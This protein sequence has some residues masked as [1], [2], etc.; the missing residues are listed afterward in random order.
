[1][2]RRNDQLINASENNN[3]KSNGSFGET[4]IKEWKAGAW[5]AIVLIFLFTHGM[6]FGITFILLKKMMNNSNKNSSSRYTSSEDEDEGLVED[7]GVVVEGQNEN[8]GSTSF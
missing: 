2:K 6:V 3:S 1:L 5:V 8:Y 7:E 4:P